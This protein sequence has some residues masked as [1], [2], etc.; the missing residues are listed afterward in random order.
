M[1]VKLISEYNMSTRSVNVK[2][3]NGKSTFKDIELSFDESP[4]VFKAQLFALTNVPPER[5]KIMLKGKMINDGETWNESIKALLKDNITL[6]LMGSADEI[7]EAPIEKTKFLEDM[8]ESERAQAFEAPMGLKNLGNT[9]YLNATIQC[10]K[11]IP[12]LDKAIGSYTRDTSSSLNDETD[13][14]QHLALLYQNF[15]VTEELRIP[16]LYLFVSGVHRWQPR[17]SEKDDHG[18]FMQ[19]DANEFYIELLSDLRSKLEDPATKN[20]TFVKQLMGIE[21]ESTTKCLESE[22]EPDKKEKENELQLSCFI[23]QTVSHIYSGIKNKMTETINK[24]SEI[25][26]RDAD[27]QKSSLICRLPGYLCVQLVRFSYKQ[28]KGV[29][30]KQLRDVKF[31]LELDLHD[32]CTP[33]LQSKLEPTRALL[34]E[35]DDRK[36]LEIKAKKAKGEPMEIGESSSANQVEF[37][38]YSLADDPGS[39]NSG[40][41]NLIAVLTHQGRNSSSGHY[42][43]WVKKADDYWFKCDD[44]KISAVTNEEVLKLSGGGDWHMGYLLFY[45]SRSPEKISK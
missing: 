38:P 15:N 11:S 20:K 1:L 18:G 32:M 40:K 30:A 7:V 17:F 31:P 43:S 16:A 9:C 14:V 22:D 35:E 23:N 29:N 45:K 25:L 42:I 8:N 41:Y 13:I 34:K 27:F 5:Q 36:A 44:D 3:T 37:E 26:G 6:M 12:E 4:D 19:Q 28:N 10:L 24:R 2:W 39:S 33:E 21:L